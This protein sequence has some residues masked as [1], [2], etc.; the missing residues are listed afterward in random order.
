[1][2]NFNEEIRIERD[3]VGTCEVPKNAYYGVHSMRA[4][5]NFPITGRDMDPEIIKSVA[6]LD[7][8]L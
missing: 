7:F 2:T 4:Y 3:S 5:E 8:L 1:M 6:L